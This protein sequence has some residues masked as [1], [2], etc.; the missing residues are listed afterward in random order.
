MPPTLLPL[1]AH[2]ER[3]NMPQLSYDAFINMC[4]HAWACDDQNCK[5]CEAL[6][7]AERKMDEAWAFVGIRALAPPEK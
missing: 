1:P 5:I 7:R 2:D 4:W 6:D 3:I